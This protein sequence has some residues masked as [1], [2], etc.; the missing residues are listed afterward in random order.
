M[1]AV[2]EN[3]IHIV[4]YLIAN[5][6]AANATNFLGQCAIHIAIAYDHTKIFQVLL[7]HHGDH[8]LKTKSCEGVLHYAA[9]SGG[10][11]LLSVLYRFN[12]RGIDPD[13]GV[14]G[15]TDAQSMKIDGLTALEIAKRRQDVPAAGPDMFRKLVEGIRHL[16]C[17]TL[18][19]Q[20]VEGEDE[21]HDAREY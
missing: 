16:E 1:L 10:L 6:A 4:N 18:V 9:Q 15:V 20:V 7:R 21:F 17:E 8:T 3:H 19:D 12:P 13:D 14:G 11:D 2:Q 5:S